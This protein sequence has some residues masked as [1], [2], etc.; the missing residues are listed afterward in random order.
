MSTK[1][2]LQTPKGFRDFLPEAKRQRDFVMEKII[3]TFKL[4]GFEPLETPTLEYAS[5]LLG[6]YG[7]D[8]DKLVY[9]FKD[10]GGREL[11]LKYDQTVPTARMLAQ[12]YLKTIPKIFRRYQIQ[13]VFRAEKPQKGRYRE[14]TQCD[15]DIFGATGDIGISDAE[16]ITCAYFAY[17]NIGFKNIICKLNQR[18]ILIEAIK[19]FTTTTSKQTAIVRLIDKLDKIGRPDVIK[20]LTD[21]G[22]SSPAASNLLKTLSQAKP[23]VELENIINLAQSLGVPKSCLVFDPALARG[24]D[25]YTSAIFEFSL[26][27][28]DS[29]SVGG[30]GRYDNLIQQ[31]GGP[32]L[33]AVGMAFGFDRTVE[34]AKNLNLIPTAAASSRVLVTFFDTKTLNQSL[35]VANQLRSRQISTEIYPLPDSLPKQLN[36][37]NKKGIPYVLIIGPDEASKNLVTLKDMK[38]G[39]QQTLPLDKVIAKLK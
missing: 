38:T 16:V 17:K 21:L 29:G 19:P 23:G 26:P 18:Q 6:K 27:E 39:K 2:L 25:Y 31:L 5:I 36:Y 35:K 24:L 7:A 11:A 14:F 34:A 8:A 32:N 1:P 4:F 33:P 9:T 30:G 20:A 12:N 28:Y 15:I 22:L 13:P 10:K 3:D 37:A